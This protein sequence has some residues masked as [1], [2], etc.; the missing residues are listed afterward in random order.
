M[1]VAVLSFAHECA[2]AYARLLRDMPGVDVVTADQGDPARGRAAAERLGVSHMD[3]WD[4]VF[5]ARPDAVVVTSEVGLRRELVERAAG[6]GAQVLCEHPLAVEE[7]DAQ[8]V[9]DAC[10]DAGVRLALA[11]PAWFSP[12]FTAVREAIAGG[13]AVGELMTLHGAYDSPDRSRGALG[14][15]PYLLDLVDAV[16][17]GE[18]AEQ[19]YAQ[20]NSVLSADPGV[21]S[22][23]LVSVRYPSGVVAAIDCGWNP[24][25]RRAGGPTM[26]FVG[27]RG[28]VE[29]DARPRLLGGFD[30]IAGGELWEPGGADPHAVM[31]GEFV[32]AVGEGRA[33]GPDG[34]AGVRALRIVRAACESARTGQPV[35]VAAPSPG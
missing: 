22:A 33:V 26:T 21:E 11:S 34:A 1:K 27:D 19:V 31:L 8:A 35:D 5:A 12:A 15:A 23:A 24:E 17:G 6:V 30:T 16:L 20:T 29:F 14:A 32:A 7:A 28:S 3:T 2:T 13:G 9:V 4:E 10:A 25:G 18:Q